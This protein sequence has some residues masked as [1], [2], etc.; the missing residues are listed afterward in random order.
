M[1][2]T[3]I[4]DELNDYLLA[5]FNRLPPERIPPDIHPEIGALLWSWA[6]FGAGIHWARSPKSLSAD[7]MASLVT[8]ILVH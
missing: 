5:W 6:I 1:F 3:A 7:E 2:E 4:Q 8:A